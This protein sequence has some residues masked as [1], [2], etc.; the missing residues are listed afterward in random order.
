MGDKV[1][2]CLESKIIFLLSFSFS[3]ISISPCIQK[4]VKQIAEQKIDFT[5]SVTNLR[6]EKTKLK[7][8]NSLKS[9]FKNTRKS[10]SKHAI[11]MTQKIEKLNELYEN[12]MT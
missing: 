11:N 7:I 10:R 5:V 6:K 2:T 4:I 12:P 1:R 9:K 3:I 8:K